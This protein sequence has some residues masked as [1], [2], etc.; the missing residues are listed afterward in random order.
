MNDYAEILRCCVCGDEHRSDLDGCSGWHALDVGGLRFMFCPKEYPSPG[1]SAEACATAKRRAQDKVLALLAA[2]KCRV[3]GCTEQ[4]PCITDGEP[5]HWVD[6]GLCSACVLRPGEL[7]LVLD[8]AAIHGLQGELGCRLAVHQLFMLI[9][10]VQLALRHPGIQG[11]TREFLEAWAM[12]SAVQVSERVPAL[13]NIL[14]AGFD[15]AHDQDEPRI[16]LPGGNQ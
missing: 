8:P 11:V 9:A 7:P 5:C 2:M 1:A 16:I 4:Q 14:A 12:Q 13:A 15:P 3:C 10:A 6:H